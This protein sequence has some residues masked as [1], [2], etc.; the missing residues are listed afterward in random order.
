MVEPAMGGGGGARAYDVGSRRVGT[1]EEVPQRMAFQG[2]SKSQMYYSSTCLT[3]LFRDNFSCHHVLSH[4]ILYSCVVA[5]TWFRRL[6][7]GSPMTWQRP[8]RCTR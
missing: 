3:L 5:G 7:L 1:Q 4:S 6:T 2:H 8:R